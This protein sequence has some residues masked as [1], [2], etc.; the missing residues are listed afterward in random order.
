MLALS[1]DNVHPAQGT[2]SRLSKLLLGFLFPDGN[3][4]FAAEDKG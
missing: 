2:A 1:E 4:S 3:I